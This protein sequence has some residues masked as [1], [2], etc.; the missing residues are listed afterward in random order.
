MPPVRAPLLRI[1]YTSPLPAPTIIPP[2]AGTAPGAIAALA[3]FLGRSERVSSR[4]GKDG[5]TLLLTGAGISVASGLADYRGT[6]GTY[7]LNKTYRPIYYNEFCENHEMRKRYWARSFLG[8]TNMRR[9]RP[10]AGHEAVAKLG[11]LGIVRRVIT[12]NV[13]SFHPKAHPSLP[14]IELHGYLRTLTCLTCKSDYS[15]NDFQVDLARLNPAWATF[16][17]EVLATGA[18]DTEN[19]DER[20]K[21]G[22]KSNPDGDVDIPGAPY[23]TFRYPACPTCLQKREHGVGVDTDGG[24]KEGSTGGVLKPSVV[25]FGESIPPE[26]KNAAEQAVNDAER[27]LVIGSSLATYSAWRLVKHAKELKLPIGI[28]NIGGVR[29]ED[30]FFADVQEG[31]TGRQA[32]RCSE[33]ADVVL[34]EV[35]KMLEG[36]MR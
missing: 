30:T 11:E 2:S 19:P 12:Q 34:P 8:W 31:D 36:S 3:E 17:Q 28:L 20:R 21:R 26:R 22:L 33:S 7:T 16:L 9:A 10:N 14:T 5:R 23:T 32:V 18:L 4:H 24:W 27:I 35:V 25:M 29:G 1:P 6:K 15:R 13:D